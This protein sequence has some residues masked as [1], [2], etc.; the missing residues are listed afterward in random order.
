MP[1]EP[2][3]PFVS[4]RELINFALDKAGLVVRI[5]RVDQDEYEAAALFYRMR[6][7]SAS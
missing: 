7:A 1:T 2:E 4:R 5:P 3:T 6:L